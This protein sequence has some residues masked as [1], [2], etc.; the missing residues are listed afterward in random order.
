MFLK[1]LLMQL[2]KKVT[3]SSKSL[4]SDYINPETGETL[5]S[6]C[7]GNISVTL[8]EGTD[9]FVINSDD[10]VI[11]DV[12]AM[13]YLNRV[14][15]KADTSRVHTM[16]RMLKTD[17]S[18]VC[19]ANNHAHTADTLPVILNLSQ[20]K[21]YAMVRRLVSKNIL[22]YCVCAPSGYTQKIYMLNPYIARRRKV[23]N[24]ELQTFFRDVTKDHT[25]P[26]QE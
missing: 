10:Y 9:Q 11:F 6:E 22:A 14:I 16:S 4:P 17:C 8:K 2:T 24:C 18:V 7:N 23:F 20:N 1:G 19:Q 25:G 13:E 15:T 21:F 26:V 5:A 3:V 12:G